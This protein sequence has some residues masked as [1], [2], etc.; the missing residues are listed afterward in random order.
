MPLLKGSDRAT[1]SANIARLVREGY[2]RKQA[3]AIAYSEARRYRRE[4]D[5]EVRAAIVKGKANTIIIVEDE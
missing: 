3:A 4:I 2:S 5:K 1:I